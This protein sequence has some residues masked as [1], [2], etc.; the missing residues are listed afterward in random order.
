MTRT[1]EASESGF[2]EPSSGDASAC[3]PQQH[4]AMKELMQSLGTVLGDRHP[5]L[6]SKLEDKMTALSGPDMESVAENMAGAALAAR[7][8]LITA[9]PAACSCPCGEGQK[10]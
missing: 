8:Y 9:R 6:I 4:Q 3:S 2:S 1:D 10:V 7:T 5:K